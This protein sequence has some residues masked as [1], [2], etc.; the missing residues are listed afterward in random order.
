MM[1]LGSAYT[2][3][4]IFYALASC[5]SFACLSTADRIKWKWEF[6][7]GSY[8]L[9]ESFGSQPRKRYPEM[10]AVQSNG[11]CN[12]NTK[13]EIR[14]LEADHYPPVLPMVTCH[15]NQWCRPIFYPV[16][17]LVKKYGNGMSYDDGQKD[18]LPN[19]LKEKWQFI[20]INLTVACTCPSY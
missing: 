5:V 9:L 8:D 7:Q 14:Q 19:F 10:V 11:V 12:C 18:M 16:P 15:G 13:H 1:S 6:D 3:Y 4:L 17:V 2:A 20:E